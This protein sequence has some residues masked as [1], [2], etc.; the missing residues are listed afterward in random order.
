MINKSLSAGIIPDLL[1]T[2]KVIPIY[3]GTVK[4]QLNN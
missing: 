3:K 4:E 2:A 1:K